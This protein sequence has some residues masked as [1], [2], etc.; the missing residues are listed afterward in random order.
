MEINTVE[1]RKYTYLKKNLNSELAI[2]FEEQSGKFYIFKQNPIDKKSGFYAMFLAPLSILL[3]NNFVDS[4][5]VAYFLSCL[6]GVVLGIISLKILHK[7]Y[8]SSQLNEIELSKEDIKSCV[9][10]LKK[11]KQIKI[12][13]IMTWIFFVVLMTAMF[14]DKNNYASLLSLS[15]L[16]WFLILFSENFNF[17][18]NN[19]V[20]KKLILKIKED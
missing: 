6:L 14:I 8:S 16:F 12:T 7:S 4:I 17:I 5:L 9:E 19:R 2:Y 10:N 3:K 11:I 18:R 13:L 15:I 1:R 20:K